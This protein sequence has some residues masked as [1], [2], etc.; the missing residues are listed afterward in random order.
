[1]ELVS[2]SFVNSDYIRCPD[3]LSAPVM[4]VYSSLLLNTLSLIHSH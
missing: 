4:F 2:Q 3:I 1:M